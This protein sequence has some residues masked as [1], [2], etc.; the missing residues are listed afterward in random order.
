[1]SNSP[2]YGT[3]T[4]NTSKYMTDLMNEFIK[5]P[6]GVFN[7]TSR[8]NLDIPIGAIVPFDVWEMLPNSDAYLKYDLQ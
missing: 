4:T 6:K 1:M 8:K 5:M 2:R 7:N 3:N